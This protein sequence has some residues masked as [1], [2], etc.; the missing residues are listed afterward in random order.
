MVNILLFMVQYAYQVRLYLN[1]E[2]FAGHREDGVIYYSAFGLLFSLYGCN[3][4]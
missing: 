2:G 4:V 3:R 1:W